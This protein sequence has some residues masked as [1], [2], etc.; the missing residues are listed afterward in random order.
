MLRCW[1]C[2]SV[3]CLA[4]LFLAGTALWAVPTR[5]AGPEPV[6]VAFDEDYFPFSFK[7]AD[8]VYTGFDVDFSRAL[9][10]RLQR[11][12]EMQGMPFQDIIPAVAAGKVDL[13]VSGMA[14]NAEREKDLL[15]VAPY[16]RSRTALVGKAGEYYPKVNAQTMNGKRLAAQIDT[17]QESFIRNKL[18][19]ALYVP[20]KTMDGALQAVRDGKAD[21]AFADSLICMAFLVK[22]EAQHLDYVAEPLSVEH[23]SSIAYIAVKA[24]DEALAQQ[25]KTAFGQLRVSD[26]FTTIAQKYFPFSIY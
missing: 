8:G 10:A 12:C 15:F 9:C 21:I 19:G 18:P 4:L 1:P 24:G 17:V 5:A 3:F 7:N 22:D 26:E 11:P 13:V 25:V 6:R 14:K 2:R 20:T 16:Y 23:E